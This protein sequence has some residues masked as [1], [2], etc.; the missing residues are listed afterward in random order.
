MMPLSVL[1]T[2]FLSLSDYA[3]RNSFNALNL[4]MQYCLTFTHYSK[5]LQAMLHPIPTRYGGQSPPSLSAAE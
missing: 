2:A 3:A 4:Q 5:E 1:N